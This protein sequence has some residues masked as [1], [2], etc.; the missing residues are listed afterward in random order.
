MKEREIQ[1]E[2]RRET[3]EGRQRDV[4]GERSER[5]GAEREG[6]WREGEQRDG[7]GRERGRDHC[8]LKECTFLVTVYS[9]SNLARCTVAYFGV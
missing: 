4:E 7:R 9:G 8:K 3:E 2:G 6:R 5:G 1:I